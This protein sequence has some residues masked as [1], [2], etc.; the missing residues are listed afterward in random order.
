MGNR[1]TKAATRARI[2]RSL[3]RRHEVSPRVL[4]ADLA[5]D[6]ARTPLA[7]ALYYDW[8]KAILVSQ[9]P[10]FRIAQGEDLELVTQELRR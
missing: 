4:R 8:D 6:L 2:R 5:K 3:N 10:L 9:L 7:S 1:N